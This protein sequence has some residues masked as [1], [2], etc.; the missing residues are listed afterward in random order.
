M[1]PRPAAVDPSRSADVQPVTHAYATSAENVKTFDEHVAHIAV[2]QC[3]NAAQQIAFEICA[4][5]FAETLE[6]EPSAPNSFEPLRMLLTGPG[7]TG[8]TYVVNCL[9]MLMQQYGRVHCIRFLAPTGTAAKLI[10]GQTIHS[11]IGLCV[12]SQRLE[13]AQSDWNLH[14]TISDV[15]KAELCAEWKNVNFVLVDEVSMI[16]QDLLCELDSV[17]RMVRERPGEWF[18]G[19]NIIFSGDFYQHEPVCKRALFM[20]IPKVAP[21]M[22]KY[23]GTEAKNRQGRIAWK[24]VDTVIELTE[25]KRMKDD[26]E[27]ATAVLRY[28]KRECTLDDVD[29]FN[30]C[31][32]KS[33]HH[34]T[35]TD[36]GLP[37]FRDASAIVARNRTRQALNVDKARAKTNGDNAPDLIQCHAKHTMAGK[38][39][40]PADVHKHLVDASDA[41]KSRLAVLDLYVGAPVILRQGNISVELGITTGAQGFV[42]GLELEQLNSGD[43]HAS[44]AIVEFD[45]ADFQLEGL[46]RNHFPIK[47]VSE[48]VTQVMQRK[49]DG[50]RW[51]MQVSRYQLPFELAFAIT[52]HSAQGKTMDCVV[53]DLSSLD[54]GGYVAVS[55]ARTREGVVFTRPVSLQDLNRPLK[56]ELTLEMRRLEALAHNTLVYHGYTSEP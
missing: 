29:L 15:K 50:S 33:L 8:K 43:M 45:D 25:Q 22:K 19:I 55:R 53:C 14:A 21:R 56:Q 12:R 48:R 40:V 38:R 27:F 46:P 3:L 26:P 41:N 47:A 30:S 34:P 52:G 37:A 11:G 42:R 32:V 35:G 4:R 6:S 31:L 16:G 5:K 2:S 39:E 44:V 20:P 36:L 9:K 18:G 49:T 17:L 10:G 54:D 24:Q 51:Q 1:V 13:N 7:G 28:R 23:E